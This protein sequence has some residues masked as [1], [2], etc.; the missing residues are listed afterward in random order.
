[1]YLYSKNEELGK[2]SMGLFQT[3]YPLYH[4]YTK[5]LLL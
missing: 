2:E 4:C 5:I 3:Y 1:M